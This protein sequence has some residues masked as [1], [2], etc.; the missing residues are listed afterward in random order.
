LPPDS[1]GW[2][3]NRSTLEMNTMA[4]MTVYAIKTDLRDTLN[5]WMIAP[6]MQ[7][8]TV[9]ELKPAKGGKRERL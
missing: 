2:S 1:K 7:K 3:G 5:A 6:K 9:D 8:T 4:G